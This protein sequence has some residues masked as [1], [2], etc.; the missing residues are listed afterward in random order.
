MSHLSWRRLGASVA[1]VAVAA[2]LTSISSPA[3]ASAPAPLENGASWLTAQLTNGVIQ[4]QYGDDVGTTI[5]TAYVLQVTGGHASDLDA[6]ATAVGQRLTGNTG[7]IEYNEGTEAVPQMGYYANAT[8]NALVFAEALEKDPTTYGGVDL[9]DR[10]ESLMVTTGPSA[11][12]IA[13]D[14]VYGNYANSIGQALA[15]RGLADAGSADA[16]AVSTSLAFLLDQQCDAGY[17][18]LN[19]TNDPDAA[20]QS[21]QGGVAS[22]DSAPDTDVTALVIRQL[23]PLAS[24]DAA[25]ATAIGKAKTWLADQQ[26]ADGSFGG[27]PSTSAPNTNSTGLAGWALG[28]LGD[29]AAATKAATWVRAHQVQPLAPCAT[30]L[31]NQAGAVAYDDAALSAGAKNGLTAATL[32]QW[33]LAAAQAVPVLQWAP[34]A[35]GRFAASGPK[36]YRK[37]GTRATYS[38][39]GVAPGSPVCARVGSTTAV[40]TAGPSGRVSLVL[41]LPSGTANRTVSVTGVDAQTSVTTKVLGKKKLKVKAAKKVK[42]GKKA[43]VKVSGLAPHEKFTLRLGKKVVKHGTARANGTVKVKVKVGKKL[44]KVKI[45]VTGQFGKIRKGVR[46]VKVVR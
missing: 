34:A 24:G 40:T 33:R 4:G 36:G 17:F 28:T 8:A 46:T 6:I 7:Y 30:K 43:T 39:A 37:A 18:R 10:L 14:S 3:Q 26:H 15:A 21:C 42:R 1:A 45:R 35:S 22:G 32:G 29:T 20:D 11:G 25:V 2:S 9:V 16:S 23:E 41:T 19:F 12:R 27:G 44:H 13:D 31:S 38:V 5:S